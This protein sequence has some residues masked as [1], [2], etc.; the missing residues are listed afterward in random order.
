M[1]RLKSSEKPVSIDIPP[2][3]FQNVDPEVVKAGVLYQSL[4]SAAGARY[5][6]LV[7]FPLST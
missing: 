2:I 5:E 6:P 4:L 7:E 1:A 3:S